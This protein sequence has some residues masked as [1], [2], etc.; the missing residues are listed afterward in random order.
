MLAATLATI[1]DQFFDGADVAA[2]RESIDDGT[3]MI[4]WAVPEEAPDVQRMLV[5]LQKVLFAWRAE[6]EAFGSDWNAR[7]SA[8]EQA[9]M[10]AEELQFL[11][12]CLA[13]KR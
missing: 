9:H 12:G 7:A 6:V 1:G 10:W 11:A 2:V 3:W 8:R 4:E 5:E 13:R